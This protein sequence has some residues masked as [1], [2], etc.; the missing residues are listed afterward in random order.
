MFVSYSGVRSTEGPSE[1]STRII[2]DD[3][4]NSIILRQFT[5]LLDRTE[6]NRFHTQRAHGGN[7]APVARGL[8]VHCCGAL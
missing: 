7:E 5:S 4:F 6:T 1:V 8:G 2:G 3:I